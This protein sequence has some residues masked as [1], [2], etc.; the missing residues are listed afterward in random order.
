MQSG[1]TPTVEDFF[2]DLNT[3]NP[4]DMQLQLEELVQ[5]GTLSPEQA[6]AIMVERSNM[7]DVN[8]DP[9]TRQAQ[10]EALAGL[11]D[12]TDS[13]GLTAIDK[14]K[15]NDIA[16]QEQ[17]QARGA[18]EAILQN[19]QARGMG[20]SGLE[21]MSQMQNQQDSATRQSGRD[22]D[23]AALAQQRALDALMNQGNLA[24][25]VG[26][27]QFNQD[28]SKAGAMDEIAKFN[29]ANKQGVNNLNTAANN[30]AQARNLA[31]KQSIADSNT[32][33][34][35]AQQQYNKQLAQQNFENELKKRGGQGQTSQFN[36]QAQ[37]QN[38]QNQANA[39]NQTI[40]TGLTAAAMFMSDEREKEDIEDF[41]ASDFLDSL[42]PHKYK[43]RD[44]KHGQGQQAGVMAQDLEK[45]EI[46]SNLV[47]EGPE[48][49]MVDYNKAGPTMMAS[50][51]DLNKRLKKM[52]QGEE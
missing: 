41:N 36:A 30:E 21:L 17:T 9:A 42:T 38:S 29:A 49:K 16:T 27:Q 46:G 39:T 15:L 34:R 7:E 8:Q 5:Q 2:K 40:G 10:M 18:R 50:L 4:A 14:A 48:G 22:L 26:G 43:Y 45:T 1:E 47:S 3:P 20:G 33:T 51:A 24:T 52:E 6:Q 44:Q 35:N 37:G 11:Q 28:A 25:S 23:V 32:G 31:A 13:G 12:I 19:A